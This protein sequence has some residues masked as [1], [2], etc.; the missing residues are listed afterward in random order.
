MWV[1]PRQQIG[2]R[3]LC[4]TQI[5]QSQNKKAAGTGY[6]SKF[7]HYYELR[8]EPH[9]QNVYTA[10]AS[11]N[12]DLNVLL[13]ATPMGARHMS[14]YVRGPNSHNQCSATPFF[15]LRYPRVRENYG[16]ACASQ[17]KLHDANSRYSASSSHLY[18]VLSSP[19]RF[20]CDRAT[21]I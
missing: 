4:Y 21:G 6:D 13:H 9:R 10:T 17:R 18:D 1:R 16:K 5:V 12:G 2:S 19:Y 20:A 14:Q 15:L 11:S 3:L 8:C 7:I